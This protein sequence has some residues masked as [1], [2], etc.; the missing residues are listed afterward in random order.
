[1]AAGC[2]CVGVGLI[3]FVGVGA[4]EWVEKG[5]CGCCSLDVYA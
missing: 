2:E 5:V 4:I 3:V 1:M